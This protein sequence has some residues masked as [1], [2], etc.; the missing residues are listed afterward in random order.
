MKLTQKQIEVLE[1][2]LNELSEAYKKAEYDDNFDDVFNNIIEH[3]DSMILE[4][5]DN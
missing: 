1:S 3:I 2:K 4:L 5:E